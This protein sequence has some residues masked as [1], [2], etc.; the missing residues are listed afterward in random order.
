MRLTQARAWERLIWGIVS[1]TSEWKAQ[2]S[3]VFLLFSSDLVIHS[4]IL[5]SEVSSAGYHWRWCLLFQSFLVISSC[6]QD[7]HGVW[8]MG[9][10]AL[11]SARFFICDIVKITLLG[12]FTILLH[13]VLYRESRYTFLELFKVHHYNLEI[14]QTEQYN[15]FLLPFKCHL[16]VRES[17]F[18]YGPVNSLPIYLF[19]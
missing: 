15:I 18:I 9:K 3:S 12:W 6:L 17:R 14:S 11:T 10:F 4:V 5:I 13:L 2:V 1:A 7:S 19:I 16:S 8:S